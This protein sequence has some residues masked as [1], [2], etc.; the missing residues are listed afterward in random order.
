MQQFRCVQTKSC[1]RKSLKCQFVRINYK[2]FKVNRKEKE[3]DD[4]DY[5]RALIQKATLHFSSHLR[6][7]PQ[8]CSGKEK[9]RLTEL[10]PISFLSFFF[11]VF[12]VLFVCLFVLIYIF[13]SLLASFTFSL[14]L[15][16]SLCFTRLCDSHISSLV[17][18]MACHFRAR[19][20]D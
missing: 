20:S 18:A 13:F 14:L 8:W 10:C 5:R 11:V 16:F 15:A 4:G 9:S 2:K 17:S 6:Y 12:L 1:T 19:I 3:M 7:H